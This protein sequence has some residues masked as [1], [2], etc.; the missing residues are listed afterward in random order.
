MAMLEIGPRQA[1]ERVERTPHL[2]E[3]ELTQ[4]LAASPRT[5][6]RWRMNATYPQHEARE[7]LATLVALADR[8]METFRTAE[9]IHIWMNTANRYLGGFTPIEAIR[10]G[11]V[12]RV[13]AALEALDMGIF[14]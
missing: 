14:S 6:H 2:S 8:L 7:R 12:D 11:R 9:A 5:V 3:Q 13:D 4:A 10:A 1:I